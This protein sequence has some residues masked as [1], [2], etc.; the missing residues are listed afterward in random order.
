[1]VHQGMA[2]RKIAEYLPHIKKYL[3]GN[4]AEKPETAVFPDF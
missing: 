1:M 2:H 4:T 3:S